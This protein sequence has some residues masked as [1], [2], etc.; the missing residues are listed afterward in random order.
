MPGPGGAE[1]VLWDKAR[2][3]VTL[4]Q[5]ED[6]RPPPGA[7]SGTCQVCGAYD[8]GDSSNVWTWE[9]ALGERP[10]AGRVL[11]FSV[12]HPPKDCAGQWFHFQDLPWNKRQAIA[13]R[14]AQARTA[15]QWR[16]KTAGGIQAAD[17]FLP[18]Q[19]AQ[20]AQ[21]LEEEWEMLWSGLAWKYLQGMEVAAPALEFL[22]DYLKRV[23]HGHPE[24][25]G[26]ARRV[27]WELE[28]CLEAGPGRWRQALTMVRRSRELG[29]PELFW[30]AQNHVWRHGF[31]DRGLW[32]NE[33]LDLARE[34]GFAAD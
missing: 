10:L 15:D 3:R 27:G 12:A 24:A 26:L 32:D 19:E 34:L 20:F 6:S 14:W 29:L 7:L 21:N 18:R 4:G 22:L 2:V 1:E 5:A 8:S 23:G 17:L 30:R 33:L 28:T 16:K 11:A 25:Q 13:L 9:Q 31:Q